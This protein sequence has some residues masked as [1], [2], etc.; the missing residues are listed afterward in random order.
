MKR[1]EMKKRNPLSNLLETI[2]GTVICLKI[3]KKEVKL[4]K[5]PNFERR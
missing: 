1:R 5:L 2:G 3:S 4:I